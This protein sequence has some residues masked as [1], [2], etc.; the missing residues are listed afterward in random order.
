MKVLN[1]HDKFVLK[2]CLAFI[3]ATNTNVKILK[4]F[5]SNSVKDK[6]SFQYLKINKKFIFFFDFCYIGTALFDAKT[7]DVLL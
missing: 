7:N 3:K 4:V 5:L 1:I 2:I 6:E